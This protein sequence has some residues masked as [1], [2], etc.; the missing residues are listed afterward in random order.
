MKKLIIALSILV[1]TGVFVSCNRADQDYVHYQPQLSTITGTL[2]LQEPGV[3]P[4]GTHVIQREDGVEFAAQSL[5]INLSDERYLGSMVEA[6]GIM[7]T[8]VEVFEISGITVLEIR[9]EPEPDHEE[10]EEND[11]TPDEDIDEDTDESPTQDISEG[12]IPEIDI[13][14]AYFESLPYFFRGTYPSQWYYAGSSPVTDGVLHHYGFSDEPVT[15]ENEIITLDVI[16]ESLMDEEAGR[17]GTETVTAEEKELFVFSQGGE[18]SV[19]TTVGGRHYRVSGPTEYSDLI[20][21]MADG[22]TPFEINEE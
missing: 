3:Y 13:E 14:L 18:F 22:I 5:S 6:T 9:E 4:A 17:P 21:N 19:Y 8:E 16:T 7:D 11:F 15:R 2:T 1:V 12:E 20:L 10:D